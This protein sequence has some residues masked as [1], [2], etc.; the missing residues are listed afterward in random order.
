VK[1]K[2][3]TPVRIGRPPKGSVAQ[4][5]KESIRDY[6]KLACT[7]RPDTRRK[8][9]AVAGVQQRAAWLVV[10]DAITSYIER[11]PAEDRRMVETIARRNQPKS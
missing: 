3:A 5:G 6:P 1:A 8:L 9:N 10:E 4:D 11:L 2:T 7:I